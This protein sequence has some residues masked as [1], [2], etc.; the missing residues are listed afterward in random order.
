MGWPEVVIIAVVV[1]GAVAL[2]STVVAA[3]AS[4]R[5]EETKG[6]WTGEYQKLVGDYEALAQE[7]KDGQ[8]AMQADLA[9]LREKVESIEKMMR[10]VA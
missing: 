9:G 8:T 1:I 10:E 3:R 7:M 6:K 4:E 2:I 5:S